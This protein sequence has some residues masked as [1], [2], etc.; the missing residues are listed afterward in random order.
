[1]CFFYL[2]H[3]STSENKTEKAFVENPT[4]FM[5]GPR[6]IDLIHPK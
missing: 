5:E 6:N 1:M 3:K 4:I 2:F